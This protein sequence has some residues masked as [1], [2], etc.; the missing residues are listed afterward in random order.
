MH[1]R[2]RKLFAAVTGLIFAL[3]GLVWAVVGEGLADSLANAM[4]ARQVGGDWTNDLFGP[5]AARSS[6]P[7]LMVLGICCASGLA[8]ATMLWE[9]RPNYTRRLL[10][11]SI[12]L[13]CLLPI[14]AY[15]YAHADFLVNRVGQALL[16]IFLIF[17]GSLMIAHLYSMRPTAHDLLALQMLAIFM[18]ALTSVL[19][20]ASFSTIWLL[21]QI[22]VIS[23]T[24]A[25]EIGLPAL[26]TVTGAI[27]AAL[28]IQKF[29]KESATS[30]ASDRQIIV[31]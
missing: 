27:S 15:N 23:A 10:A 9:R 16:N 30:E 26:S 29:R 20:P 6:V 12:L 18:L 17:G 3:V 31:P 19:L 11:Y 8:V 24:T 2:I 5:P 25:R 22:G 4:V 7:F 1:T 21:N 28:A 13:A 14:S